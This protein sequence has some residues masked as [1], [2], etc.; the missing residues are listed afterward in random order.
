MK[1]SREA[2]SLGLIIGTMLFGIIGVF[3][4]F[5]IYDVFVYSF[6]FSIVEGVNFFDGEPKNGVRL[7]EG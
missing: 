6:S 7:K 1:I 4:T 5:N 2:G 3:G